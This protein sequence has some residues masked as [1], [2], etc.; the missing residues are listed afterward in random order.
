MWLSIFSLCLSLFALGYS[1]YEYIDV[2]RMWFKAEKE[3]REE[4][5]RETDAIIEFLNRDI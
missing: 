1:I 5:N 3:K 2:R 4:F